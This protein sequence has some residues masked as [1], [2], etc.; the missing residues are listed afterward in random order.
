MKLFDCA[1]GWGAFV[2]PSLVRR[3]VPST[4]MLPAKSV[5]VTR[6]PMKRAM[7]APA[8]SPGKEAT[9]RSER[10]SPRVERRAKGREETGVSPEECVLQHKALFANLLESARVEL[11]ML[12]EFEKMTGNKEACA[13]YKSDMLTLIDQ[14]E[15]EL[16]E[17]AS[18]LRRLDC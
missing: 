14:R 5:P 7:T 8:G 12:L 17:F 15:S 2:V 11:T 9:P 13:A 6:N 4:R 3:R 16:R 18:K 1:A 10:V